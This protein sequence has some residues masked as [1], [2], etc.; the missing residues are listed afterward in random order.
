MPGSIW[1]EKL[2]L[3]ESLRECGMDRIGF[4]F[5]PEDGGRMLI[6]YVEN[7]LSVYYIIFQKG[8][9]IMK[10]CLMGNFRIKS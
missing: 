3:N 9:F 8:I 6:R 1:E 5:Y 2:T 4:L 7:L 10:S